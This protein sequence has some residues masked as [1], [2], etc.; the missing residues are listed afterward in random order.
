MTTLRELV[1]GKDPAP[2]DE[3]KGTVA[4]LPPP[5]DHPEEPGDATHPTAL[6]FQAHPSAPVKPDDAERLPSV[7]M[8]RRVTIDRTIADGNDVFRG[9]PS[10]RGALIKNTG[11]VRVDVSVGG[12]TQNAVYGGVNT[13]SI[14]PGEVVTFSGLYS[15]RAWCDPAGAVDGQLCVW[16]EFD[17]GIQA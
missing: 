5:V 7:G 8:T 9:N 1:F 11:T 13:Y 14:S 10:C 15:L 3:A 6:P 12:L 4:E 17:P 16:A 2:A